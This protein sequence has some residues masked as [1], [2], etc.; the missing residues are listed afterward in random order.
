MS[1][2]KKKKFVQLYKEFEAKCIKQGMLPVAA[3]NQSAYGIRP[4]FDFVP[5]TKEEAQEAL[6]LS[7]SKYGKRSKGGLGGSPAERK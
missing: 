6:K 7:S 1:E 2:K 4:Y 3:L 5:L